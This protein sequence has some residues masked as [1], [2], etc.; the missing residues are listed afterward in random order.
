[1]RAPRVTRAANATA[2][3]AL[4]P[5][6]CGDP[7]TEYIV[8]V[9][10]A[11][12]QRGIGTSPLQRWTAGV[13]RRAGQRH[14]RDRP[15]TNAHPARFL[16]L[17]RRHGA[18]VR[19]RDRRHPLLQRRVATLRRCD[20]ERAPALVYF[21]AR[22]ARYQ[23]RVFLGSGAA[24][25]FN[26]P[27]PQ[28]DVPTDQHVGVFEVQ[29]REA[30]DSHDPTVKAGARSN[31]AAPEHLGYGDTVNPWWNSIDVSYSG[32]DQFRCAR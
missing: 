28:H 2:Q 18:G 25:V 9:Y 13:F 15:P 23:Q 21:S 17:C 22:S 8:G 12:R 30:A 5:R 20:R 1:M 27:V 24:A 6:V 7:L 32:G 31:S 19:H 26:D 29:V 16:A 10:H 11:K 14:G 4:T 3:M